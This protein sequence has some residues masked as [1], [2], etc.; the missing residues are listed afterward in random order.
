MKN[1][2]GEDEP[3]RQCEEG[4]K[5]VADRADRRLAPKD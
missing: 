4:A 1:E 2:W 5:N 3:E